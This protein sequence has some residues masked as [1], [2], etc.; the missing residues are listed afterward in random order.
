ML[1]ITWLL[2]AA[3]PLAS[4]FRPLRFPR[5]RVYRRWVSQE[6]LA[7]DKAEFLRR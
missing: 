2:G 4:M 1:I 3:L 7:A 5:L 6:V